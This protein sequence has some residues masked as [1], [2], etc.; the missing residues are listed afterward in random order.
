MRVLYNTD[1]AVA[2]DKK[3]WLLGELSA[4]QITADQSTR[5]RKFWGDPVN[6]SPGELAATIV[7]VNQRRAALGLPVVVS[8]GDIDEAALAAALGPLL[9]SD[10][11]LAAAVTAIQAA[12][13]PR[14]TP[15]E[16]ADAVR[17]EIIAPD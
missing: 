12:I 1:T 10:A 9:A 3:R 8:P 11:D 7:L 14:F 6:V 15:A 5:E 4:Q 16:I 13:P 2:D 17:D